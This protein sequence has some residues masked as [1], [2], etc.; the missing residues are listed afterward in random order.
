MTVTAL[1]ALAGRYPLGA[2]TVARFQADGHVRLS[3]V[4]S[5]EEIAT[6]RTVIRD[7]ALRHSEETRALEDRDTYGKA[8]LQVTN[9]WQHDEGVARFTLAER[10]ARLAADLLGVERVRLYHDQALFKEAGGGVTPWH[11]DAVYWPLEADRTLTMWIPLV[12]VAEGMGGMSFARGSHSHRSLADLGIS[13]E[14]E[15]HFQRLL[16]DGR[17]P[18]DGPVPMRAGDATFHAGWTLHRAHPNTSGTMR[19]VMT[20]IYLAD[21]VRVTEPTSAEQEHDLATWL[22]GL[23]PGDIVDSPLNPLLPA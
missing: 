1:P 18:V 8:F 11:Q 6:Y 14:S 4:A 2:D 19:E 15:G 23:R 3:G 9:L 16:E 22:P 5:P 21:G 7:A 13:D 20:V 10:F 17:F 12:D